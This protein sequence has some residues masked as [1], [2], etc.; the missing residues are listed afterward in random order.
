MDLG[1]GKLSDLAFLA[2]EL[3]VGVGSR[4]GSSEVRTTGKATITARP[5]RHLSTIRVKE[6]QVTQGVISKEWC[7]SSN[8]SK[9][10]FF[11]CITLH[12]GS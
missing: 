11:G 3:G 1:S 9:L 5:Q 4:A 6:A 7:L 8:S 2:W 10:N 12:A